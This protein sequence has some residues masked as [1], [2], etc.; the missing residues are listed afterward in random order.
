[1]SKIHYCYAFN[2][3]TVL[4]THRLF[5]ISRSSSSRVTNEYVSPEISEAFLSR[6][7]SIETINIH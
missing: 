6:D 7:V 5:C 4:N 2:I 3:M 1:M